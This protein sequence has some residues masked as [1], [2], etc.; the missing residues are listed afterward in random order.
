MAK[1]KSPKSEPKSTPA[2]EPRAP[3]PVQDQAPKLDQKYLPVDKIV[4]N[5]WNP[6]GMSAEEFNRLVDE[7]STVGFIAPIQV[8]PL[9]D[10]TY[11]ILGGE[12][13]WKA[14]KVA[15]LEEIP[16][17]ILTDSKWKEDDLKK[18][19]TT[20][21]NLIQGKLDPT[22]FIPLYNEMVEKYGTD[23]MAS[24]FGFSHEAGLQE[25]ISGVKKGMKRSL[26]K[27]MQGEF[28][29]A[30]KE[31]KTIEDL[32]KIIQ[33]IF[34]KYGSTVSQNFM[35]FSFGSKQH[36]YVSMNKQMK[37]AMDKVL[38]FCRKSG[39]DINDFMEPITKAYMQTAEHRLS[40]MADTV[41]AT[42]EPEASEE[43]DTVTP[44]TT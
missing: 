27:E 43:D 25:I 31:V 11:Q 23:A 9:D 14:A 1:K 29:K 26:P 13:R 40:R 39:E 5:P 16:C 17:A 15:G 38:E 24:L 3:L 44:E 4:P 2:P 8:V 36:I 32:S 22:K 37:S 30:A 21:L 20:R 6:Q 34:N 42:E 35:V 7:I 33:N 10:G 41:E 18:F 28:D 12:H 19:T